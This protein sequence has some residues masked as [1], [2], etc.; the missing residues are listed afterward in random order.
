[1]TKTSLG[2]MFNHIWFWSPVIFCKAVACVDLA[3]AKGTSISSHTKEVLTCPKLVGT[4]HAALPLCSLALCCPFGNYLLTA[5][6]AQ[7]EPVP[8]A[9]WALDLECPPTVSRSTQI[10]VFIVGRLPVGIWD[11]QGGKLCRTPLS[12]LLTPCRMS[13][14]ELVFSDFDLYLIALKLNCKSWLPR[15]YGTIQK[16]DMFTNNRH[17]DRGNVGQY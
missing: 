1:M 4:G 6:A 10:R 5:Q 3:V 17:Q 11:P 12:L 2:E 9:V 8:S 15:V 7:R 16:K 13:G 14:I